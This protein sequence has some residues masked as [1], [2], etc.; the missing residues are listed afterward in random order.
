VERGTL[1]HALVQSAPH[2]KSRMRKWKGEVGGHA[3]SSCYEMAGATHRLGESKGKKGPGGRGAKT[4]RG[5]GSQK[6]TS[7]K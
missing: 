1:D 2:K 4:D 3:G 7:F 6:L 5:A